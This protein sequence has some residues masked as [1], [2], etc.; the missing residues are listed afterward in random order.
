MTALQPLASRLSVLLLILFSTAFFPN[1][2]F[3]QSP[4]S[5][6][7]I[8]LDPGHGGTAQSDTFRVGPTGEREEWI[9]LRVALLLDSLLTEEGAIVHLTRTDD[10]HVELRD[11]AE[12]AVS[13]GADLFLS[14]HH[15]AIGDPSVNFP[16]VYFHGTVSENP[17]GVQLARHL[18]QALRAALFDGDAPL[19]IASDHTIFPT[20]GTAVLRHSYGIPGVITEA[21]FFTHPNEEQSLQ[22]LAYNLREAE[23]LLRGLRAFF[24][25]EQPL[26]HDKGTRVQ[27]SPFRGVQAGERMSAAVLNW[28]AE[29][30]RGETLAEA[31]DPEFLLQALGA[32]TRSVRLFPDSPVAREA[33][34]L[35]ARLLE[36]RGETEQANEAALRASEH[37]LPVLPHN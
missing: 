27:L 10:V 15:N 16:M 7:V 8:V 3:S 25:E 6:K 33:H 18:G 13:L 32:L 35:R 34:L 21:S 12:L 28:K 37:Y 20:A 14:I 2:L 1:V 5:D 19:V 29:F 26:I 9:N 22:N 17:A 30:R 23:A 11:R 24:S 4:L 36:Q 31:D